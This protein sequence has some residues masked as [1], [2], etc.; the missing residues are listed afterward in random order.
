M[1]SE[2]N[3]S[4][5]GNSEQVCVFKLHHFLCNNYIHLNDGTLGIFHNR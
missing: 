2:N 1:I 5:T 3:A 4:P